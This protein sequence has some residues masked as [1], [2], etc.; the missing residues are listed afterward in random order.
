MS[1]TSLKHDIH[2]LKG[3][4]S[5]FF[6]QELITEL[7]QIETELDQISTIQAALD[8]LYAKA[9]SIFGALAKVRSEAVKIFGED[10]DQQGAMRTISLDLLRSLVA[11]LDHTGKDAL[12]HDKFVSL[13]IGEPIRKQLAAFDIGLQE[14][15]ERYD[16]KIAPCVFT[17]EN[18][19]IL[20]EN[21][22]LLFST[23]PHISRN[24]I[25]HAIDDEE[26]RKTLGKP[27][28][29][30]VTIDTQRFERAG[31]PW[32]SISFTDDGCGIDVVRL[33]S[34]LQSNIA[35]DTDAILQSIFSDNMSTRDSADELAGRGVGMGAIKAEV[36]KLGGTIRV[37]SELNR[38]TRTRI[39]VPMLWD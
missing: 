22:D 11:E 8:F 18:F 12:L 17:G 27:P 5:I 9:P 39:E 7:H 1:L 4:A 34:K 36:E 37:E 3:N 13:L 2:T 32:F 10:F 24:I 31:K 38:F 28:A 16:R 15:A 19:A 33:R 29:L 30:T 14:L 20:T 35:A 6:L 26:T 23:F 25:A 21:Y